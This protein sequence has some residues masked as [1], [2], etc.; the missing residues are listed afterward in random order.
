MEWQMIWD[1]HKNQAG[2]LWNTIDE[3]GRNPEDLPQEWLNPVYPI[4]RLPRPLNTLRKP[5]IATV[6]GKTGN[7][8]KQRVAP[9][10]NI[11]RMPPH[12]R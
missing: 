6:E 1:Y 12:S 5:S 7:K 10:R 3:R 11:I 8:R 2:Q 4:Y 9:E